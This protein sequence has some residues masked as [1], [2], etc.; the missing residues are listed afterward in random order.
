MAD[1][2][3]IAVVGATG[4]QGNGL[5]KAILADKS[6]QFAARAITRNVNSDK[7]KALAA[8]GAEVVQADVD[9]EASLA[10]SFAGAYGA[11]CVTFFWDHFSAEKEI[12]E[13]GNMARAAKAA[14]VTH[15][16]WSTLEDTRKFMSLDDPRMPTLQ[17]KYKVAHF[18]GKGEADQQFRDAG[19]PTTFLLTAF[20][21]ENFIYFG[22]GPKPAGDGT[23]ALTMPMGKGKLPGI[24]VE[25]IG[26]SALGVFKRPDLIGKTVG[27]A[28]GHL[29]GDE[30]AAGLSKALGV[31]VKYNDVPPDVYRGFGFPG[32]DDM[33]NMFQFKRD[34]NEPYVNARSLAFTRELNPELQ[35]YDQWLASHA[36]AI[37]LE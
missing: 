8:A 19:V 30:M 11:F 29:T 24:A 22:A 27:I 25:D 5:V 12:A 35:T 17:G 3:I 10:R 37:P 33:G 32:A 13:A 4:A 28:G 2:K 21:W 14:G 7:A 31:T 16:V 9:D 26:K 20:Y 23:F 1:K 36:R 18:D 15:V 34:F 6:G